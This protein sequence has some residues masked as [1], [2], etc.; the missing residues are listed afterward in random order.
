[1]GGNA[2]WS[3]IAVAAGQSDLGGDPGWGSAAAVVAGW[4]GSG[5]AGPA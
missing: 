4:S 3:G 1:L 2:G 5:G